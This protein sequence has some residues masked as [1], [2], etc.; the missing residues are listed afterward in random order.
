VTQNGSN[1]D[2]PMRLENPSS[3]ILA[4]EKEVMC[5]VQKQ[6]LLPL[7]DCLYALQAT[8]QHLSRSSLHRCY[9]HHGISRLPDVEGD[10]SAKKKFKDYPRPLH[11]KKS[12]SCRTI[13]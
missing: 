9:Q 13:C 4:T 6:T 1:N 12:P 11:S 8:I 2:E 3:T 5:V 7:D 10:K